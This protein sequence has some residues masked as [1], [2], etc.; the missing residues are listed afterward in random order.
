[1]SRIKLDLQVDL[2]D[3]SIHIETEGETLSEATREARDA[4]QE[5]AD[6]VE[7]ALR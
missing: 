4:I 1:M 6:A 2:N 7:D 3:S 5:I